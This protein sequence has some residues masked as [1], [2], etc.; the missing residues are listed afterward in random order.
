[1]EPKL[2]SALSCFFACMF[3]SLFALSFMSARVNAATQILYHAAPFD[4]WAKGWWGDCYQTDASTSGY[5]RARCCKNSYA[6]ALINGD[7]YYG[8]GTMTK[9]NIQVSVKN[10]Y[11]YKNAPWFSWANAKFWVRFT[12]LT[13]AKTL[14]NDKTKDYQAVQGVYWYNYAFTATVVGGH[15]YE[16]EAGAWVETGY[17]WFGNYGTAEA[18]GTID[19]MIVVGN[20]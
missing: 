4:G 12:D 19:V 7:S 6:W 11:V 2:R 1:M 18:Y 8:G 13:A 14:F 17:G 9:I 16:L 10:A 5:H 3:I 20:P 15:T